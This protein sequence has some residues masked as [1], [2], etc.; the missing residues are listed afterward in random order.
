MR[1]LT[2][3]TLAVMVGLT[4]T[5]CYHR[6][7]STAAPDELA[8]VGGTPVASPTPVQN[9]TPTP[10]PSPAPIGCGLPPAGGSGNSCPYTGSAFGEDVDLAIAQAQKEHPELFDF[11]DGYGML[12]WRVH[13]R[14]RYYD[15]VKLNLEK[16]GYCAAHDEEEIG[17]KNV[18]KFNEQYQIMTSQ[19]Y[20][21]WGPGAYRATCFPAWF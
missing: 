20:S 17:V 9:P 18:N 19:G 7:E 10:T 1:N 8:P 15:L 2:R 11:T 12:S 4:V 21:R 13:D 14:K 16:M 3:W 5:A 6:S